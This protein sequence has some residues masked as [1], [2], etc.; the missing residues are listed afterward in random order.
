[1]KGFRNSK[2]YGTKKQLIDELIYKTLP[3]GK[4]T[5]KDNK[6]YLFNRDY[7]PIQGW[8]LENNTLIIVSSFNWIQ[9]IV[10]EE[11]Y[12]NGDCYPTRNEKTLRKCWDI[13]ADWNKRS[14]NNEQLKN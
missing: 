8:D 10:K 7:E 13:L 3:Y 6:E 1:M 2:H 14:I 5:T 9:E 4:W 12:Y 11:F